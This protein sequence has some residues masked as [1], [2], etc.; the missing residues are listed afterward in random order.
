MPLWPKQSQRSAGLEDAWVN[1]Q[2]STKLMGSTSNSIRL[3]TVLVNKTFTQF[4]M[5]TE[6][7]NDRIT[8]IKHR[9]CFSRKGKCSSN[10]IFTFENTE[11]VTVEQFWNKSHWIT[12]SVESSHLPETGSIDWVMTSHLRIEMCLK[13]VG[14][15]LSKIQML[16]RAF[17]TISSM[18]NL[19]L[20]DGK[21]Y[22]L[23]DFR[24][25]LD[26]NCTGAVLGETK[27][28]W[29]ASACVKLDVF[30]NCVK[31]DVH[32]FRTNWNDQFADL[33]DSDFV[34]RKDEGDVDLPENS[35]HLTWRWMNDDNIFK[36]L[37]AVKLA[38][39]CCCEVS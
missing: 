13:R 30:G 20:E 32:D 8:A 19:N 38:S 35:E 16:I 21:L 9:R 12:Q 23:K 15:S 37:W 18:E 10:F 26:E 28:S 7:F 24:A 6:P 2:N 29:L 39:T 34:G 22:L 36:D 1:S 4:V 5:C 27:K 33:T 31:G 17:F 11:T 3:S 14:L 25:F